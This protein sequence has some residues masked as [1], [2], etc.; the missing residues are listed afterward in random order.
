MNRPLNSSPNKKGKGDMVIHI[1]GVPT[2][3]IATKL[4][5]TQSVNTI[6]TQR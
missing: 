6:E 5:V 3:A 1:G 4:A 2:T